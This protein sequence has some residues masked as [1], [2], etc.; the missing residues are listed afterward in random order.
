[1]IL[2]RSKPV[3]I[4]YSTRTIAL[5]F[6]ALT[7]LNGGD[8]KLRL[9][10]Y[11]PGLT[12]EHPG[13]KARWA[14]AARQTIEAKNPSALNQVVEDVAKD[15]PKNDAFLNSLK[16][17]GFDVNREGCIV[18]LLATKVTPA[19]EES[20][21]EELLS[22]LGWNQT[23][24]HLSEGVSSYEHQNWA[25]ANAQFRTFLEDVFNQIARSSRIRKSGGEARGA[26]Q[27]N[28]FLSEEEGEMVKGVFK[29]LHTRGSH[30]GMSE[31]FEARMRRY[32]VEVIA[33]YFIEKFQK[34]YQTPSVQEF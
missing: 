31:E 24:T 22:S 2:I 5:A 29:F 4:K 9:L 16:A 11:S 18:P 13:S 23:K 19:K 34:S 27:K 12:F 26:L 10:R 30:P 14:A 20:V 6:E 15:G 21:L 17:D 28:G 8:L 3:A 33:L 32:L 1:M 25:A 7:I